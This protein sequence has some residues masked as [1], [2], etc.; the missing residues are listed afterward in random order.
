M[1]LNRITLHPERYPVNDRY[2][3]NL[4][5]FRRTEAVKFS[6]PVTLFAGE[7]GTG[8]ST[9]LKAISRAC[10]IHIW[11]E[12]E[13]TRFEFNPHKEALC[14]ALTVDWSDGPV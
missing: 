13:R 1:H 6:A 7:N 5:V 8:K 4:E 14:R 12:I 2:P 3:F 10:G 11:G 9:L